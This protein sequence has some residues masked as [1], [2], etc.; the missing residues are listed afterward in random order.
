MYLHK[1]PA[2][3]VTVTDE[4]YPA[5][6]P[7]ESRLCAVNI[8]VK[9]YIRCVGLLSIYVIFIDVPVN[10]YHIT[11]FLFWNAPFMRVADTRLCCESRRKFQNTWLPQHRRVQQSEVSSTIRPARLPNQYNYHEHRAKLLLCP[12]PWATRKRAISRGLC[13][14][15][16]A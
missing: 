13:R 15:T 10:S 11:A 14:T 1:L 12:L 6:A 7:E 5:V 2:A 16:R 8:L 9:L 3:T 4:S